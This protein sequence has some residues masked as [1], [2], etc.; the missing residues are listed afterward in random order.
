MPRFGVEIPTIVMSPP[1]HPDRQS[2]CLCSLVED[3][4]AQEGPAFMEGRRSRLWAPCS[5]GTE[6]TRWADVP[7]DTP[8]TSPPSSRAREQ[9]KK[10]ETESRQHLKQR[11]DAVLAL[12]NSIT[13]N[14]V[15]T[16]HPWP[17]G[18]GTNFWGRGIQQKRA[19]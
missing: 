7:T 10:Q 11:M 12:K 16:A 13:A 5:R 9:E 15:G 6:A 17:S 1:N 18:A 14:R 2:G 4:R 19:A 8:L 3:D